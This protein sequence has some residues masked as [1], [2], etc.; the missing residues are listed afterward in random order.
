M[1]VRNITC[2]V[3]E[4]T[5]KG[6]DMTIEFKTLLVISETEKEHNTEV[7]LIKDVLFN[8]HDNCERIDHEIIDK[9]V[10]SIYSD[11]SVQVE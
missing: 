8:Q 11:I 6:V 2:C 3:V 4:F 1:K 7:C 9:K 10:I 5:I